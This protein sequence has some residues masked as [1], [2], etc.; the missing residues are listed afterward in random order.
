V[1]YMIYSLYKYIVRDSTIL[2]ILENNVYSYLYF[3]KPVCTFKKNRNIM[4]NNKSFDVYQETVHIADSETGEISSTQSTIK[5]KIEAEPPFVKLYID[6]VC[7]LSRVPKSQKD[8]LYYLIK[9]LD[10]D[11]YITISTRYRT[12]MAKELGVK[13]QSIANKI[14]ELAKSGLISVE[15]KN[16]YKANPYF[17]GRGAWVDILNERQSGSF[18]VTIKYKDGKREVSTKTEE[19]EPHLK[20]AS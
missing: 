3:A 4:S 1:E 10:Y 20:E 8:V 9:K 15:G 7:A 17:F 6:D 5:R 11:G 18:S 19:V 12:L 13:P 14:Q 2:H 16:E